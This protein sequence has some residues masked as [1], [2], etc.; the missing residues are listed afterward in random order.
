S[1]NQNVR[2]WKTKNFPGHARKILP[3]MRFV[4]DPDFIQVR[5]LQVPVVAPAGSALRAVAVGA[6]LISICAGH[7]RSGERNNRLGR[8][9][10]GRPVRLG[11]ILARTPAT[12]KREFY[13]LNTS[14]NNN[15]PKATG[16]KLESHDL[17]F[18]LA[19]GRS[20]MVAVSEV[21]K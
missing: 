5:F 9:V 7:S 10:P 11:C 6:K 16:S 19:F 8:A 2:F 3:A 20:R 21:G 13:L 14:E 17:T 12:L 18:G 1:Q 15:R 4:P